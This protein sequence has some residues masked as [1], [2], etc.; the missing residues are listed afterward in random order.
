MGR[1]VLV[2]HRDGAGQAISQGF[3][4]SISTDMEW[5]GSPLELASPSFTDPVGAGERPAMN[6]ELPH[7]V[8]LARRPREQEPGAESAESIP[9]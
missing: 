2:G 9:S 7:D 3:P 6:P 8:R 4:W 5:A 1:P